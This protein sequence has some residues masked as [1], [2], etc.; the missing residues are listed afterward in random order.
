MNNQILSIAIDQKLAGQRLDKAVVELFKG[1]FSRSRL[2]AWIRDGFLTI[3]GQTV[4]KPGQKL[5]A[6]QQLCLEVPEP[7]VPAPGSQLE[8]KILYQDE[9]L[10]VIDKP[11]GLPMH[12]NSVGDTQ[13]CVS[14]WLVSK[15]GDD[16][17]TGQGKERPGIVHRLDKETSGVCIVAFDE[18]SFNGLQRQFADRS[19]DK[20]YHAICYGVPRFKSDWIETRLK[21]DPRKPTKVTTTELTGA[22]TR[23]ALSYW[24]VLEYFPDTCLLS[25]KP[26]TGRKHQI[27]VHLCS[28]EMPIVGDP[29]Y[30][31]KNYGQGSLPEDSPL[32][33]RTLLHAY[34]ITFEHP[35]S[36]ERMSFQVEY[37]PEMQSLLSHLKANV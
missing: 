36:K 16:L 35:Q 4:V 33:S 25:I 29:Y 5:E 24:E 23:D 8:P 32:V 30:R 2:S 37:P 17:P 10:A 12:A 21:A 31:A 34:K 15:F 20:E 27:R 19:V 11:A 13:M 1:E 3:D 9:F 18:S 14:N 7:E 22:G 6:G 26:S 28:V